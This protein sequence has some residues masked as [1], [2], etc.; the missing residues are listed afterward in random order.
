M[1]ARRRRTPVVPARGG[2]RVRGVPLAAGLLLGLGVFRLG[3]QPRAMH[4][5][6]RGASFRLPVRVRLAAVVGGGRVPLVPDRGAR[7]RGGG[8][9]GAVTGGPEATG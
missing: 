5:L 7:V 6:L 3:G 1:A 8:R 4:G 9:A 2:R